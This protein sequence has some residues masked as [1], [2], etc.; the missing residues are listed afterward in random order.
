[1]RIPGIQQITERLTNTI[2]I[3]EKQTTS[4]NTTGGIF[5]KY[6]SKLKKT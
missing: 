3:R 4:T 6:K 2:I 5:K 1:M